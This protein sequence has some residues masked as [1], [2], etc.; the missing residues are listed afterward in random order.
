MKTAN[1]ILSDLLAIICVLLITVGLV[2][3]VMGIGIW[4]V[5]VHLIL[6]MTY[7]ALLTA[8]ALVLHD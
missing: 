4:L 1:R 5:E 7:A 8:L 6:G 3:A 2:L